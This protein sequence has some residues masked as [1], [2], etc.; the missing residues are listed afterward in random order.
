M[1]IWKRFKKVLFY[2]TL[3]LSSFPKIRC[4][5]LT[6]S[7]SFI[8]WFLSLF[9]PLAILFTKS[10]KRKEYQGRDPPL[11]KAPKQPN[12]TRTI[13]NFVEYLNKLNSPTG[14]GGSTSSSSSPYGD[15][16]PIPPYHH[17]PKTDIFS[18][19]QHYK[20]QNTHFSH[21]H[22]QHSPASASHQGHDY[23]GIPRDDNDPIGNLCTT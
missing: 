19:A 22:R 10:P 14:L 13:S 8:I 18:I 9:G 6:S 11:I 20:T 12:I 21:T 23:Q 17:D 16:P 2:G 4:K 7:T 15:S 1:K 5:T 3:F